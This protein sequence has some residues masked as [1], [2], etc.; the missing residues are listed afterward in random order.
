MATP[1]K[2]LIGVRPENG[3]MQTA[4]ILL[5]VLLLAAPLAFGA[6]EPWAWATLIIFTVI[7]AILWGIGSLRSAELEIEWSILYIPALLFLA[8]VIIQRSFNL[9]SDP[10]STRES[11]IKLAS[12]LVLL[13]LSQQLFRGI[14]QSAWSLFGR[15]ITLYVFVLSLFSITQFFS[16][17]DLLYGVVAPRWGGTVFGPYVN[18]NHYAGLMEV[19]IPIA[20]GYVVALGW[21]TAAQPLLLFGVLVAISSV[22]VSGSRGGIIALVGEFLIFGTMLLR[23][24]LRS[25]GLRA[26]VMVGLGFCLAILVL[27]L[28][29]DPGKV[30]KRLQET[31]EAPEASFND[32]KQ[33][34]MSALRMFR[35]HPIL[36]IGIGSFESVYPRYQ[37]FSSD[38]LVDHAHND[39]AEALAEGGIV[40]ALLIVGAVVTFCKVSFA[41]KGRHRE[42]NFYWISLGAAVGCCGLL[43]HSLSDFNLH[44]PANAAWFTF[45]AGLATLSDRGPESQLGTKRRRGLPSP[46]DKPLAEPLL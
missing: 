1:S 41:R 6:V 17:P 9:T 46:W 20:L 27:F 43:I 30:T 19:V 32:R 7:T 34:A 2:L 39:Y 8:L 40:G 45:A 28:W 31:A 23:E 11:C 25:G 37:T 44:I 3:W 10:I 12:Y 26:A 33:Y 38:L 14:S 13:F 22:L 21:G 18:H 5:I 36:G 42:R 16:S 15:A 35:D 4:R 24:H 29:I